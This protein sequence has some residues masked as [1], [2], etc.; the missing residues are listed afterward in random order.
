MNLS[1][2]FADHIRAKSSGIDDISDLLAIS[3]AGDAALE[4][5]LTPDPLGWVREWTRKELVALHESGHCFIRYVQHL[6]SA[7]AHF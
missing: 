1:E 3:M 6:T 7:P 4:I 5:A 2:I